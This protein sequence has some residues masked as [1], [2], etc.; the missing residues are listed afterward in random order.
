MNSLYETCVFGLQH[1]QKWNLP[2]L[3]PPSFMI[4][5]LYLKKDR[6]CTSSL[7][8]IKS[9][10]TRPLVFVHNLKRFSWLS[11]LSWR[12]C[13][14]AQHSMLFW[15]IVLHCPP[16]SY[17]QML[18]YSQSFVRRACTKSLY[19]TWCLF[20]GMQRAEPESSHDSTALRDCLAKDDAR[21]WKGVRVKSYEVSYLSSRAGWCDSHV[22]NFVLVEDLPTRQHWKAFNRVL[23]YAPVKRCPHIIIR[24]C[25]MERSYVS[26]LVFF[27]T[28]IAVG[29]N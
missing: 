8:K 23:D 12:L 26:C 2:Q 10:G 21:I 6:L 18:L 11:R 1:R 13:C 29:Q 22:W 7:M 24:K 19:E 15:G 3:S 9:W 17:L 27:R 5:S 28:S 14:T 4:V 16:F 20:F 25:C